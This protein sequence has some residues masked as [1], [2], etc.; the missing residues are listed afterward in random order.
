MSSFPN[1]ASPGVSRAVH[2]NRV[3]R[4]AN[5][6]A[7]P[8]ELGGVLEVGASAAFAVSDDQIAHIYVNDPDSASRV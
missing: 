2:F 1:T 6:L 8:A 5:L 3:L 4:S 7:V